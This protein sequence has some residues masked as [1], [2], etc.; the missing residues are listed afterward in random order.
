M[1]ASHA[2]RDTSKDELQAK[3]NLPRC[4]R[5][6]CKLAECRQQ[7]P[8]RIKYAAEIDIRR[9]EIRMIQDVEDLSPELQLVLL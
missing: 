4:C 9:F 5:R 8:T 3:L 6:V 2:I 7:I 1:S